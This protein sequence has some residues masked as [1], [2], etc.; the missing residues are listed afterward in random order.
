M[1]EQELEQ[2]KHP[3]GSYKKPYVFTKE[4]IDQYISVISELPEKL[5]KEI[6]HFTEEQLN[7][8]YRP[9][10]WTIRQVVHHFADSHING[11]I[12]IKMVLTENIPTVKTYDEKLWAE[13]IDS[14]K[15]SIEPS[16]Q[17]ISGM[18]QRWAF[19]LESLEEKDFKKT[20]FHPEYKREI[21]IDEYTGLYAWHCEHHTAQILGLKKRMNWK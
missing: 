17:I 21:P 10:G 2:I 15:M 3:I 19:L 20:L 6:G 11:F 8:S 5:R 14:T 1:T 7:T 9:G 4:I 18:H 16:L 12:R 13:L